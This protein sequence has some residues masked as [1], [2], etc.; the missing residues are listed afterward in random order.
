MESQMC[1]PL[2]GT[3]VFEGW[4]ADPYRD[5]DV[6]TARARTID[7]KAAPLLLAAQSR[8]ELYCLK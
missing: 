3:Y 4:G 7:R 6:W 1:L 5:V 2:Q 8:Y